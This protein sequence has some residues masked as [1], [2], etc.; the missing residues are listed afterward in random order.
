MVVN[1]QG[2]QEG[3]HALRN[4]KKCNDK[5]HDVIFTI[6]APTVFATLRAA[7]GISHEDFL[8]VKKS[9]FR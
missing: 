9:I 3:R 6:Y 7:L 8:M 1:R 4:S 2:M 5:Q